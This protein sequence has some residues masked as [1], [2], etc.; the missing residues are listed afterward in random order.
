MLNAQGRLNKAI[1][2]FE[3]REL[4]KLVGSMQA[5]AEKIKFPEYQAVPFIWCV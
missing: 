3:T 2:Y 5:V 4:K 1:G